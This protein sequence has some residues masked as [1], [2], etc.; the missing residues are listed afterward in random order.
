LEPSI[1]LY[2]FLQFLLHLDF[3]QLKSI[4]LSVLT[5]RLGADFVPSIEIIWLSRSVAFLGVPLVPN[6]TYRDVQLAYIVDPA[7]LT[8]LASSRLKEYE[9]FYTSKYTS[10]L[11]THISLLLKWV[12]SWPNVDILVSNKFEDDSIM[13][14]SLLYLLIQCSS[15]LQYFYAIILLCSFITCQI[16]VIA[17]LNQIM[18]E[19][20]IIDM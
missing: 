8:C 10:L 12:C 1:S 13:L 3:T 9:G 18:W 11:K 15:C 7:V 5:W 6:A 20:G 16:D 14:Y 2:S 19:H 17:H 4:S